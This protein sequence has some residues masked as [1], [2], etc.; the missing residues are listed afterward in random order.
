V[1]GGEWVATLDNES[2]IYGSRGGFI[3][4]GDNSIFINC[5]T[6]NSEGACRPAGHRH[7]LARSHQHR[8][9]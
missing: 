4:D 1:G 5:G 7:R 8:H 3:G 6:V 2:Y 9:A